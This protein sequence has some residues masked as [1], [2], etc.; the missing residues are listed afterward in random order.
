MVT[1]V[2]KSIKTIS[3]GFLKMQ[4]GWISVRVMS[5]I[6]Y[7][8][9][10]PFE[11]CN[12]RP[13]SLTLVCLICWGTISITLL[14]VIFS[15]AHILNIICLTSD[16]ITTFVKHVCLHGAP[17]PIAM[18]QKAAESDIEWSSQNTERM[19]F[20]SRYELVVIL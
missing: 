15:G 4:K 16:G 1:I 14:F 9:I 5:L 12:T 19:D 7:S 10:V 3:D 20:G 11:Y 17:G 6:W 13:L 18:L 8:D 2:G